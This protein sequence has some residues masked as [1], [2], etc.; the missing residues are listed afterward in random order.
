MCAPVGVL[1]H[2]SISSVPLYEKL[3]MLTTNAAQVREA[4]RELE[5]LSSQLASVQ[6]EQSCLQ[7][8]A[9]ALSQ[10]LED[11]QVALAASRQ[12]V[13]GCLLWGSTEGT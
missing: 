1:L 9:L 10:Q 2:I 6:E 7:D 12:E 4:Q 8:E 13:R 5:V 3:G 11:S